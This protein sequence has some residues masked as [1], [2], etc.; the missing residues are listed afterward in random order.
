MA[1][2]PASGKQ[3]ETFAKIKKPQ[4]F[5]IPEVAEILRCCDRKVWGCISEGSLKPTRFK[6]S[7]RVSA[8]DLD[9]FL[10]R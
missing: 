9:A 1:K 7:T 6:G 3:A 10:G 8:E 4:L 5:T 2:P